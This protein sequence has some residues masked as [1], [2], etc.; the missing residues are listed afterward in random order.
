MELEKNTTEH[1][2]NTNATIAYLAHDISELIA[3]INCLS[4]ML[5]KKSENK[6][7][8]ET[9]NIVQNIN[10]I[11]K[12]AQFIITELL[13]TCNL[14]TSKK[15]QLEVF[16]LNQLIYRQ[17]CI[18]K[19]LAEEKQVDLIIS[20]PD[21]QFFFE[22]NQ[23]RFIMLLN[24]LFSNALK[25]A[26][27]RGQIKIV[28]SDNGGNAAILVSYSETKLSG[29]LQNILKKYSK[30]DE[31]RKEHAETELKLYNSVKKIVELQKGKILFN[32]SLEGTTFY[33]ELNRGIII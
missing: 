15:M 9:V 32:N 29:E 26:G 13:E 27:Q 8:N 14:K 3:Q 24:N 7:D 20:I 4:N 6:T 23:S 2:K 28:L 5:Y 11:G 12:Q 21:K 10:Q 25:A 31:S 30:T 1:I 18:Y 19:L 22:L 33:I 17:S 16:S